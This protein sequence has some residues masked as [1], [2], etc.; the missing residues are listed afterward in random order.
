MY[1]VMLILSIDYAKPN[2]WT[3]HPT[4]MEMYGQKKVYFVYS[5][6][7]SQPC[8]STRLSMMS[9]DHQACVWEHSHCSL[10]VEYQTPRST[11]KIESVPVNSLHPALP[12]KD[13]DAV[14]I[15]CTSPSLGRVVTVKKFVRENRVNVGAQVTDGVDIW[16]VRLD[17]IT[18]VEDY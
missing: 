13:R 2:Q 7:P 1:R 3:L 4:V 15:N 18:R 11:W 5:N 8:H 14:I 9:A 17:E 10:Q 12:R 16:S 6:A